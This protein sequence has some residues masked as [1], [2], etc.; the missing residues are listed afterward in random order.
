MQKR[1]F[2]VTYSYPDAY[3]FQGGLFIHNQAKS[4]KK[5]GLDVAV[6]FYDFRSFRKKRK[7]G[8]SKYLYEGIPVYRFA[9]PCGPFPA[10]IFVLTRIFANR[11]FKYAVKNE[12][13]PSILHAHFYD[14]GYACYLLTKKRNVP[15]FVTEH[16]SGILLNKL[17][18][19]ENRRTKIGYDHSNGVIAVSRPLEIVV[20][21]MTN[22]KTYVVPNIVPDYFFNNKIE[23]HEGFVFVSIGNIIASKRF[24][25]TIK[26]FSLF[27]KNVLFNSSLLIVG[28]GPLMNDMKQLVSER[29]VDDSVFFLGRMDNTLIPSLLKKCDCFLLPSDYETFGVVFV[30][31]LSCGL[32]VISTR[33]GG[34]EEFVNNQNGILI[35]NN[36]TATLF[37]AMKKIFDNYNAFDRS[38]ISN[39]CQTLFSEKSVIKRIISIYDE[40]KNG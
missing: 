12:G 2:I 20:K 35:D 8:L 36:D 23:K 19:E 37:N 15:Y 17:S 31:A 34:P 18:R 7:I 14:A 21:K 39:N 1:V 24:D 16:S 30:E 26:A 38:D 6:L 3:G 33:C 25:L 13:M 40:C 27:K 29:S 28:D 4:L 11:L 9:M 22:N 32:P 5:N 10:L